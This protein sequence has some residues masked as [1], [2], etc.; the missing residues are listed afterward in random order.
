MTEYNA[1]GQWTS[2]SYLNG[3]QTTRQY[4]AERGWLTDIDTVK[5][6]TVHQQLDYSYY[7]D[8]MI[9]EISSV[10]STESWTYTYDDL[11]RL[12][13]GGQRGYAESGSEL[14]I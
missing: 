9:Q 12:V 2:Q 3:V 10:K 6:G 8:G 4:F 11:N 1:S 5:G 7:V 13:D 14:S